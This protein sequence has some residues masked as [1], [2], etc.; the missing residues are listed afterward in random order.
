MFLISQNGITS[1]L[2][3]GKEVILLFTKYNFGN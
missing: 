3:Y 2:Q 1:L